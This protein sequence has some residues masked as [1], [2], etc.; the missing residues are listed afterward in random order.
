MWLIKMFNQRNILAFLSQPVYSQVLRRGALYRTIMQRDRIEDYQLGHFNEVWVDAWTNLPFYRQWKDENHLPDGITDLRELSE[1]PIVR[2]HDLQTAGDMLLR[3]G[4]KPTHYLKTGGSTG[5]PL[6]LGAWQDGGIASSSQWLGRAAYGYYPGIRTFLLWGHEHLYGTGVGRRVKVLERR[7]KDRLSNICRVSAYDLS[8]E[9]MERAFA[10]FEAYRPDCVIGFAA[11]VLAFSRV[12]AARGERVQRRPQF[13]MCT[14]GPLSKSEKGEIEGF[15]GA[16]VCM[17]YGSV[18]CSVMGYTEPGSSGYGV[19]WDTHLI[20][21]EKDPEGGCRN[22]VTRLTSCYVPLIRYD[23]GDYIDIE[24]DADSHLRL[25]DVKGRPSDIVRLSD[26]TAFFGALIGDCVK[27][28]DGVL[29]NQVFVYAN[30]IEIHVTSSR[31][32]TPGD[33]AVI[34]NRLEIVVPRLR[35]E[36]VKIQ[37][38][39]SLMVTVGGKVPLVVHC[40][41]MKL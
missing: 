32:L 12:N 6:C 24:A 8:A 16:N 9:A 21:G 33:F 5:Q 23:V 17:E 2:K 4:I 7:V 38:V 41:N 36:K 40:E 18:E 14:A 11:A 19:F 20:Q 31:A 39:P 15:F 27:Q 1:W 34:R 28:V 37:S 3:C 13:V 25:V 29:A 30:G 22:I 26:G 10:Q 35:I